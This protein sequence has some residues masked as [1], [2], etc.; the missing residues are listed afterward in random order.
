V[1]RCAQILVVDDK[2]SFCFLIKG[3]LDDAGYQASCVA[4]GAEALAA[5]EQTRFDLILSDM[6]MPEM[7]GACVPR[8]AT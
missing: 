6:V 5:L 4:D 2:Q 7:D 3:Y 1:K 8:A